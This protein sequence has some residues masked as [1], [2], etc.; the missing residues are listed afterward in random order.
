MSEAKQQPKAVEATTLGRTNVLGK[1]VNPLEWGDLWILVVLF[2]FLFI[3]GISAPGFLTLRNWLGT[4]VYAVEYLVLAL[5]E[6]FVIIT[7]GID[8]SVG[9][10]LGLSA[11]AAGFVMQGL[12]KAG[13][14]T[15]IIVLFGVIG[16]MAAGTA[17]GFINGLCIT[18]L[19]ISPLI[20]TLGMLGIARGV[21]FLLSDGTDITEIPDVLGAFANTAI[22]GVVTAPV[23]ITILTTV[24]LWTVLH[25]TRFG[26]YTFAIGS[27][28]E[29]ARLAGI[30]INRHLVKVYTL[31]GFLAALDGMLIL[32]RFVTASPLTGT[33]DELSAISATVI[34]G[35]SLFGG[36]GNIIGS[37]VGAII[38]SVLVTGLILLNVQPYWQMVAIGVILM[39]AVYADQRRHV[40]RR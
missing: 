20:V 38:I 19:K 28:A 40:G 21:T 17:A 27:N 16:G 6:T 12:F 24:I 31:S 32:S 29:A 26:R 37:V 23:L 10:L 39:V 3:F 8:L 30:N 9:S 35:I 36:R 1:I 15:W 34:G 5:G 14:P 33:N 2:A 18:R 25:K 11:V 7:A 4:S 22:L 13:E